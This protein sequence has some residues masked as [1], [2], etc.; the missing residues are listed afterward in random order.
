MKNTNK[1]IFFLSALLSLALSF[2]FFNHAVAVGGEDCA[3]KSA[4]TACTL[5][6][7]GT[8]F[9]G[10]KNDPR[11]SGADVCLPGSPSDY[12]IAGSGLGQGSAQD[13]NAVG[14]GCD[15][16]ANSGNP[17]LCYADC[18]NKASN[19]VKT[20]QSASAGSNMVPGTASNDAGIISCG[21]SGR[22]MCTICDIIAGMNTIIQYLIKISIGLALAVM[23]IAGIIYIV[24]AGD[25]GIIGTAKSAMKNAVIGFFVVLGAWVIVNTLITSLGAKPDLGIQVTGWGNFQC[26]PKTATPTA[27]KK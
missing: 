7:G 8:G 13:K 26:A 10:D 24:S 27:A 11:S 25:T 18:A 21:R 15:A 14:P 12:N 23:T 1:K 2:S 16:C 9:C 19:P 4:G 6:S 22:P 17:Q 5:Y 3:G 20:G